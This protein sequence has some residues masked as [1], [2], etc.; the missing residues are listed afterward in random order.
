[1]AGVIERRGPNSWRARVRGRQGDTVAWH[2]RYARTEAGA[3]AALAELLAEHPLERPRGADRDHLPGVDAPRPARPRWP[4]AGTSLRRRGRGWLA[5]NAAGE[6]RFIL[7]REAALRWLNGSDARRRP[8]RRRGGGRFPA[9]P[10]IRL[11]P[12]GELARRLG[13]SRSLVY[14]RLDEGLDEFEA[15]EW[16]MAVHR[17]PVEVWGDEWLLAAVG[18]E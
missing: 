8:L 6:V 3:R 9:G 18:A 13:V 16:A 1:M 12:V 7:E 17:H 11:V 5:T 15:D 2:T 4:S 10:L 14:R